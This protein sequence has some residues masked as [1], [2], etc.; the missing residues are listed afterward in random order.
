M[1]S[2]N[3]FLSLSAFI[4]SRLNTAFEWGTHDCCLFAADAVKLQTGAD[5][6]SEY[7]GHY[8]SALGANRALR[9]HGHLSLT[10]V[11]NEK[12][13]NPIP[14]LNAMRGD[15]VLMNVDG[16]EVVGVYFRQVFVP[17][18]NGLVLLPINEA[19]HV[20]RVN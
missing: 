14:R 8:R 15:I 18:E 3:R 9:K 2:S 10:S 1:I 19:I 5:L 7:R 11:L 13:G 17:G 20:W 6:A 12:L 4:Q 16:Q